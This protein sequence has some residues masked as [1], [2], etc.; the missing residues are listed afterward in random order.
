M[1]TECDKK[2]S[3]LFIRDH[4][5][6]VFISTIYK[7]H[8]ENVLFEE[9]KALLPATQE[10]IAELKQNETNKEELKQID[11]QL[12]ELYA[13]IEQLTNVRNKL[14]YDR[15]ILF[16]TIKD[17]E[18]RILLS[19][20]PSET[21]T[22]TTFVRHCPAP[23]C[24]GFVSSRWKCGLC[25]Q[26]TCSECHE[27]KGAFHNS[28]H[29]CNPELVQSAK[30][31]QSDS[32]PC[33][34]C[35]S[36]IYKISGC[37]QMWCTQC[38]TAFSWTTGRIQNSTNIHN[39]HYFEWAS[40]QSTTTAIQ[41]QPQPCDGVL[42]ESLYIRIQSIISRWHM[43]HTTCNTLSFQF[44]RI[45]R[46]CIHLQ[47]ISINKF[48][49]DYFEKNRQ[50]RIHYLENKI[51]EATFKRK[52][53]QNNKKSQ[54]HQEIAQILQ[55]IVTAVNDILER[56]IEKEK[57]IKRTKKEKEINYDTCKLIL[58]ET[59]DELGNLQQYA[60]EVFTQISH[61]YKSVH[62]YMTCKF[63]MITENDS[64]FETLMAEKIEMGV[65]FELFS[66]NM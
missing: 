4:F 61:V 60:N 57:N 26:W 35:H 22:R 24:R 25:E 47:E 45:I 28:P 46:N 54:Q 21:T 55:L 66:K 29:V 1:N 27:I 43:D 18:D 7:A 19:N 33:P 48:R 2:W 53:Y 49:V 63:E 16:R 64:R 52:I 34:K 38:N 17:N 51:D 3:L 40:R 44:S 42:R 8:I 14:R 10:I 37:S 20:T 41:P 12:K 65:L 39:P 11:R 58:Q 6:N 9:E 23:D 36:L 62:Y 13:E 59:F 50:I 5:T 31:I 15:G 30:M 32:K 56:F